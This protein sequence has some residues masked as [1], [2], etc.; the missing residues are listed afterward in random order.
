MKIACLVMLAALT[1]GGG[2]KK[3]GKEP[4]GL[5]AEKSAGT[6]SGAL[7]RAKKNDASTSVLPSYL[8]ATVGEKSIG[9]F[10]AR[11]DG[12]AMAAYIGPVENGARRAVSIP[13]KADG[14]TRGDAQ[15]V[16]SM[17]AEAT[18]LVLRATGGPGA[19]FVAAWTSLTERGEALAVV[20]IDDAG[21]PRGTPTE[22]ARTLDDIVWVDIVPTPRGALCVWAE[23]TRGGDANVL[24]VALD[25]DGKM[26]GVPSRVARGVM[27]WQT[28]ATGQG[29]ALA[30]V[31]TARL[32]PP[33]E[34]APQQGAAEPQ[35]KTALRAGT[36]SWLRLDVDGRPVG[37]PVLVTPAPTVSG[38][39]EVVRLRDRFVFAWTD[40]TGIDPEVALASVSDD[41]AVQA[42]RHPLKAAGGSA[43]VGLVAGPAGALIAWDAPNRRGRPVRRVQFAH[44]DPLGELDGRAAAIDFSGRAVPELAPT[45]TGFAVVGMAR[46]GEGAALPTFVRFDANLTPVQS[47]PLWLGEDRTAV[48]VAWGL[49]CAGDRCTTLTAT[50][51]PAR[52]HAVDIFPRKSAYPAPVVPPV[53]QNAP[54]LGVVTTVAQGEPF[55]DVAVASVADRTLVV[56]LTSAPDDSTGAKLTVRPLDAAGA[57]AGSP[58]TITTRA[59][60]IGGAAIAAGGSPEHGAAVAWVARENG[61]PEVHVT[62]VDKRG[63]RQNDV[64]LTTTKGAAA[65][66]AIAWSGGGWIVAWVDW[67]NGNGEVYATKVGPDL[68]RVAREERI[69]DASGDATDV[70]L[71]PRGDLVWLA[72]ADPRES[73]GDGFADVFVTTLRSRDAKRSGNETRV[74]ASAAHSRSP[75]LAGTADGVVLAWIEEAPMGADAASS[76]AH[77]AMIARLDDTGKPR[78]APIRVR[79]AGDGFPSAIALDASGTRGVVTRGANDRLEIDTIE[80]APSANAARAFPLFTLDGPP[81]LDVSLALLDGALYYYDDGPEPGDRRARRATLLFRK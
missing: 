61:D 24:A 81:S 51:D 65:D 30:L 11:R 72:W 32:T 9:P 16:A 76:A 34:R 69:T 2:C 37:A 73:P 33:P 71:L 7:P 66:V 31:L 77:G 13:L 57:P 68:N 74:L 67:R 56:L 42:P 48:Q 39:V 60:P 23:E 18:A 58:T 44:I 26:R 27:G 64:Q 35:K 53:S 46:A 14:D 52:V 41:G 75:T 8:L 4:V 43:M 28:A 38:D 79:G 22:L 45:D 63:K 54:R 78:G 70:T 50:G 15:V 20:G 10:V 1:V 3:N 36:L 80:L 49:G 21:A 5:N 12:T 29:A 40:R 6:S 47:E 25:P 19:G 55:A 62:R 17:T 59:L